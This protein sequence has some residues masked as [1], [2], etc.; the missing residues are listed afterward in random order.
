MFSFLNK[1]EEGQGLVEYALILVLVA[2]VSIVALAL[3]GPAISNV[4]CETI[5]ELGGTCDSGGG[6]EPPGKPTCAG[7]DNKWVV[8]GYYD[9][10]GWIYEVW[11][12]ETTAQGRASDF[13]ESEYKHVEVFKCP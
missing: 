7:Y 12:N 5:V 6:G 10:I 4:Y 8:V 1:N 9:S 3:V 2:V 13:S 11:D